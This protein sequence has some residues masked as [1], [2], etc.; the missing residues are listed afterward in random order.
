MRPAFLQ[1]VAQYVLNFLTGA[2]PLK[3]EQEALVEQA[4]S[5]K[6]PA[7]LDQLNAMLERS[8]GDF[9]AGAEATIADFQLW[10]EFHNDVAYLNFDYSKWGAINKWIDA[11]HEVHGMKEMHDAH[12]AACPGIKSAL[13]LP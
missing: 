1:G 3:P 8:E 13:G 11:C 5:V 12:A 4:K 2:G 10:G 7:V 6:I 9:V